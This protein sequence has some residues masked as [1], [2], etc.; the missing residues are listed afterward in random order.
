MVMHM[1]RCEVERAPL[2]IALLLSGGVDSSLALKLLLAAG[3]DV[4]A[5]YL[6]V[7]P[8]PW[9][10]LYGRAAH[11]HARMH[12]SLPRIHAMH[13]QN[14]QSSHSQFLSVPEL[15]SVLC[16]SGSRR[17]SGI[18]GMPAPGRMIWQSV[19]RWPSASA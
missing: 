17:T 1:R 9:A 14:T 7:I 11:A 19:S 8:H 16:R 12:A 13:T 10:A 3:H 2:K 6:Q 15:E 4:T 18:P 5:F